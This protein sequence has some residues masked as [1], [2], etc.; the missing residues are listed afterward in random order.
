[1]FAR[2]YFVQD[3][4]DFRAAAGHFV[5]FKLD[6]FHVVFTIYF[7][8]EYREVNCA[9]ACVRVWFVPLT[10]ERH[11]LVAC[12]LNISC[13]LPLSTKPYGFNTA[14]AFLQPPLLGDACGAQYTTKR[15]RQT[16]VCPPPPV[17][18]TV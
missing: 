6:P 12:S 10:L 5:K 13:S 7:E 1:M 4:L 16:R 18:S 8:G 3:N 17:L 9:L 14:I 11:T 2:A 15:R